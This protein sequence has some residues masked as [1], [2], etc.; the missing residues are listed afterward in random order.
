MLRFTPDAFDRYCA[1]Y[2]PEFRAAVLAR[3]TVTADF[4]EVSRADLESVRPPTSALRRPAP[5]GL[6]DL[7]AV[8]AQPIARALDRAL[9]TDIEHCGGCAKRRAALNALTRRQE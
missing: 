7:V 3:A 8:V 2:G 6:G 1:R 4:I 9:G 5:R